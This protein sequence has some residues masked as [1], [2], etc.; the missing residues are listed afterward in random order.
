MLWF[1]HSMSAGH[2]RPSNSQILMQMDKKLYPAWSQDLDFVGKR[3]ARRGSAP[4]LPQD[5]PSCGGNFSSWLPSGA[6]VREE[7]NSGLCPVE[8][9]WETGSLG[10]SA[11][12]P[13][14]LLVELQCYVQICRRGE[15]KAWLC[16]AE[17][18]EQSW[19][20]L[21]SKLS[22]SGFSCARVWV[23]PLPCL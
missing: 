16:F 13:S 15:P 9:C 17:Q 19:E 7:G 18:A 3:L 8:L 2:W 22:F 21:T 14:L 10:S 12:L 11:G 4:H 23:R 1:Y 5:S 20:Q 6:G